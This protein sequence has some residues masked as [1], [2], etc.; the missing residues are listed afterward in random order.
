MEEKVG[1]E[2]DCGPFNPFSV[3]NEINGLQTEFFYPNFGV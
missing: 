1:E 3:T 2:L